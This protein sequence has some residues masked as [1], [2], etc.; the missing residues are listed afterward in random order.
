MLRASWPCQGF[1]Q[2]IQAAIVRPKMV[3]RM[4]RQHQILTPMGDD[5]VQNDT[6]VCSLSLRSCSGSR[7]LPNGLAGRRKISGR[8]QAPTNEGTDN[9]EDRKGP[10]DIFK[11]MHGY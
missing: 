2:L 4:V 1:H 6:W 5:D 3:P 10:G 7:G 8:K 9:H 11:N